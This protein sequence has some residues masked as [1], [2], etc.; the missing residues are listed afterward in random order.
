MPHFPENRHTLLRLNRVHDWAALEQELCE[1]LH[2]KDHQNDPTQGVKMTKYDR[3]LLERLTSSRL[4]VAKLEDI[5]DDQHCIVSLA[6]GQ[7]VWYAPLL[8]IVDRELLRPNVEVL[9]S[10]FGFA[11]VG[12]LDDMASN[13]AAN[14]I[15]EATP[16]ETFADVGESSVLRLVDSILLRL[17]SYTASL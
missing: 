17:S 5:V 7:I 13:D 10:L 9:V 1:R 3:R 2:V 12:V 6:N 15:V 4:L 14:L 11:V 16:L 8:S